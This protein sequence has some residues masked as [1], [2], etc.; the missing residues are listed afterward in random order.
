MDPQP[1]AAQGGHQL[2]NL[3]A[4]HGGVADDQKQDRRC[5]YPQGIEPVPVVEHQEAQADP[6]GKAGGKFILVCHGE[7]PCSDAPDD[8]GKGMEDE[9]NGYQHPGDTGMALL[10]RDGK[11]EK[12]RRSSQIHRHG[13]CKEIIFNG[14]KHCIRSFPLP[15]ANPGAAGPPLSGS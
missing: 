11:Q 8:Q 15:G 14:Q 10:F 9:A 2:P 3:P 6:P 7:P 4:L 12:Q 5:E 13:R 1:A